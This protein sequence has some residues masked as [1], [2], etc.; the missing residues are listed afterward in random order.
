MII[1][2]ITNKFFRQQAIVSYFF[3]KFVFI[4]KTITY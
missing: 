2:G 1:S 4:N 3:S